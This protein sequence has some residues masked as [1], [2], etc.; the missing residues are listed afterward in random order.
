MRPQPDLSADT[1]QAGY[2]AS[3]HAV[4]GLTRAAATEGARHGVRVNAVCPGPTERRMITSIERGANADDPARARAIYET[5][6]PLRRYARPAE[7]ASVIAFVASPEAS[8]VTGAILPVDG[9]MS[10][11]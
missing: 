11:V 4:V 9:G 3:K 10:A 5:A 1:P 2:V 6:I 8:Y 7:V